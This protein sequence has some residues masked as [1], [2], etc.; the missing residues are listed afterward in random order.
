MLAFL[1]LLLLLFVVFWTRLLL[2]SY[3]TSND[4]VVG[5]FCYLGLYDPWPAIVLGTVLSVELR[6]LTH[7][8]I[9][10]QSVFTVLFKLVL[11]LGL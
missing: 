5:Q 6:E 4:C 11:T 9:L 2:R 10:V 8:F 1:L 7:S 3:P